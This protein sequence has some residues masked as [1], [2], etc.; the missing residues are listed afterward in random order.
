MLSHVTH[1]QLDPTSVC[2][3]KCGYCVGR[4]WKQGHAPVESIEAV[5]NALPN[6]EYVHVQGEGEPLLGRHFFRAVDLVAEAGADLG[7]I[8]NGRHFTPGNIDKLLASGAK[9]IGVSV[10]SLEPDQ[11]RQIRGGDLAPVLGGVERLL[12][13]RPGG[14]TDVYFTVVLM[15]DNFGQL[16]RIRD[17][18]E[19]WGM[20][21]P[22]VQP[23]QRSP[24]YS[25]HYPNWL[26]TQYLDDEQ[27]AVVADYQRER[28]RV[29]AEAGRETFFESLFKNAP[30]LS[31]PF[32]DK[33][34]HVRFDGALFPCCFMKQSTPAYGWMSAESHDALGRLSATGAAL[35]ATFA[36]REIPDACSTCH[37]VD[38]I[39]GQ[40]NRSDA[41][42]GPE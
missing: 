40:D 13:R 5:F 37:L 2:D 28:A 14:R 8:T 17:L 12:S 20:S 31:C 22:S 16:A 30:E 19:Q 9:S 4:T 39:L 27:Q 26:N 23:L 29:R 11:Y 34:L 32:I 7:L 24:D 33:A 41:C 1:L 10:D 36:R 21:P 42:P 35:A 18:S 25:A 38:R 15:K 3:L 6:L